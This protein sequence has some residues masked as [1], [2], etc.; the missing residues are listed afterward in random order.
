MGSNKVVLYLLA[1]DEKKQIEIVFKKSDII[2]LEHGKFNNEIEMNIGKLLV[3][4]S[5]SWKKRSL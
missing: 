2:N 3:N 5:K 1:L 4:T